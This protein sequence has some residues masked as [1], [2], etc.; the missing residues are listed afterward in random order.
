MGHL[1][2]SQRESFV[3]F[4]VKMGDNF[5][6]QFV[7]SYKELSNS[8]IYFLHKHFLKTLVFQGHNAKYRVGKKVKP[9]PSRNM[10]YKEKGAKMQ[11]YMRY[12]RG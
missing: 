4:K 5:Q 7:S 9:L 10:L 1:S 8:F 11:I 6:K 3:I 2:H 12:I